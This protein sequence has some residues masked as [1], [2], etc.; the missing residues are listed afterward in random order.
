M[1][2]LKITIEEVLQ[3]SDIKTAIAGGGTPDYP[4]LIYAEVAEGARRN[5]AFLQVVQEDFSLIG[6]VG[7]TIE[8]LK[9]DTPI[10]ASESTE[11]QVIAGMSAQ[12]KSI[13]SVELAV[14]KVIW[15][16]VELSDILREDYPNVEWVRLCLRDMGKSVMETL[17][18]LVYTALSGCS[19]V[20]ATCTNL[21]YDAITDGLAAME[22]NNWVADPANPPFLIMAPD[23][24]KLIMRDTDFERTE[25]YTTYE[26]SRMV[27]GELGNFAGCRV[28]KS[29]H[30]DGKK[31]AFIVFPPN[32]PY[33][34]VVV[35]AWKRRLTVKDEYETTKAYTYINVSMR[36][37]PAVIQAKGVCRIEISN[38]P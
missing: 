21:D 20:T 34:P 38:T 19:T 23:S 8:F 9:A 5:L 14:P 25:R 17:D 26:I 1:K 37:K 6:A 28:L 22:N 3:G 29:P 31:Y 27:Q 35:N 7:H 30:L 13:S 15:S 16:A 2:E 4:F 36:A 33:G 11:A 10:T 12:T 32:G 18:A 24:A